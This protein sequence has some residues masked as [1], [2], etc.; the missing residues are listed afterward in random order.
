MRSTKRGRHK[1]RQS[2]ALGPPLCGSHSFGFTRLN[3]PTIPT[4]GSS[5]KLTT[6]VAGIAPPLGDVRSRPRSISPNLAEFCL[7]RT[8]RFSP[9]TPTLTRAPGEPPSSHVPALT[10]HTSLRRSYP[11]ASPEQVRFV[12][13]TFTGAYFVPLASRLSLGFSMNAVRTPRPDSDPT[14][15][16]LHFL[17]S[18]TTRGFLTGGSRPVGCR[19]VEPRIARFPAGAPRPNGTSGFPYLSRRLLTGNRTLASISAQTS[20]LHAARGAA[21]PLPRRTDGLRWW[22]G[23]LMPVGGKV[24]GDGE[25]CICDRFFL[26]GP[27]DILG[28]TNPH[29]QLYFWARSLLRGFSRDVPHC[30]APS[31]CQL[32]RRGSHFYTAGLDVGLSHA[33]RRPARTSAH[34]DG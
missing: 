25:S 24:P 12:K 6:E 5:L 18:T 14:M 9:R 33:R 20:P 11:T 26:G 13:Q 2:T 10:C 19:P 21:A 16:R 15:S 8:P 17:L 30:S 31:A 22:Q 32:C 3:H 23:L 1:V 28:T 7:R 34:S 29:H 27:V 4:E